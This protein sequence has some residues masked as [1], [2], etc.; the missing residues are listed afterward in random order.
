MALIMFHSFGPR[1]CFSVFGTTNWAQGRFV[2]VQNKSPCRRILGVWPLRGKVR[3][4]KFPVGLFASGKY[5]SKAS[6][7]IMAS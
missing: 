6:R 3:A 4:W 2:A 1:Y 7:V 5:P